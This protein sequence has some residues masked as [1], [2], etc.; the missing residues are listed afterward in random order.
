MVIGPAT[1]LPYWLLADTLSVYVPGAVG[2]P[3][4]NPSLP[5]V[6][7]GGRVPSTSAYD[8]AGKPGAATWWRI[9]SRSCAWRGLLAGKLGGPFAVASGVASLLAPPRSSETLTA[10]GYTPPWS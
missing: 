3:N 5:S 2:V 1:W 7:P 8:G 10:T 6:R 9:A 4:R